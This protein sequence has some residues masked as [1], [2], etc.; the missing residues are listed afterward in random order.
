MIAWNKNPDSTT[1]HP[2]YNTVPVYV[3]CAMRTEK[4]N[5]AI[6][7]V[8]T[9]HPTLTSKHMPQRAQSTQSFFTYQSTDEHGYTHIFSH[10][11]EIAVEHYIINI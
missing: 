4:T 7:M 8:R 1:L 6:Q 5:R 3:G 2:G 11:P 10:C 9:A